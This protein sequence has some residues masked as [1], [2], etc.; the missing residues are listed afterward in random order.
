MLSAAKQIET[1]EQHFVNALPQAP[2]QAEAPRRQGVRRPASSSARRISGRAF[3]ILSFA[4]LAIGYWQSAYEEFTPK[5]G[6]GYWLGIAGATVLAMQLLYALRKRWRALRVFGSPA[7][8]FRAHIILGIAGP[9]LILYHSNYSLGATNSNVALFSMLLVAASG[10]VGRYIYGKIHNGLT[11]TRAQVHDVLGNI[12]ALLRAI[13]AD[14]G[15]SRGVIAAR[16]TAFGEKAL[17]SRSSFG[18]QLWSLLRMA[19]AAPFAR[20]RVLSEVRA[21]VR[22]NAERLAWS[23]RDRRQHYRAAR[24]HVGDYFAGVIR[25][26]QL[27]CYERLFAMWH[28]LHV[29]IYAFLIV[30]AIVHI[31]AV[32]L[33]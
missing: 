16:L 25:A 15:G 24:A 32:H 3:A 21:A 4:L 28:V 22:A 7:A 13:E 8:W 33:Y 31:V 30:T 26:S 18:A 11:G 29:P 6:T 12:T 5:E 9:L 1:R 10:L 17:H 19:V 2:H 14:V 27:S 20:A 23:R